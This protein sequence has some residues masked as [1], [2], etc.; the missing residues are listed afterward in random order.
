LERIKNEE[1]D[2]IEKGSGF[3]PVIMENRAFWL[4]C[5]VAVN[6]PRQ[7]AQAVLKLEFPELARKIAIHLPDESKR[8][9]GQAIAAAG[10]PVLQ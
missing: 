9:V 2:Q 4:R 8:R 10:L 1:T 5:A 3:R 6:P 7:N